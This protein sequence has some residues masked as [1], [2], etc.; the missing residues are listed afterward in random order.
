[1]YD[2]KRE[3]SCTKPDTE[4]NRKQPL[5][6]RKPYHKRQICKNLPKLIDSYHRHVKNCFNESACA[7]AT[8]EFRKPAGD[9]FAQYCCML[10]CG[11]A[12]PRT[13]LRRCRNER[14]FPS[15]NRVHRQV[16]CGLSR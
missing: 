8:G 1:M 9:I 11:R 6:A 12:T 13:E 16:L 2:G 3:I 14:H 7:L 10:V 15:A 4:M 5:F